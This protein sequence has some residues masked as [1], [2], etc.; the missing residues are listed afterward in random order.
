MRISRCFTL[1]ELLVVIAIIA[2]LAAMLLP[3]L[4]QARERARTISC[5]NNMK[6]IGQYFALY[7]A[8]Y[9]DFFMPLDGWNKMLAKHASIK[10]T[11][12]LGHCPSAPDKNPSGGSLYLTYAYS[13]D[14]WN[15]AWP[16]SGGIAT[17]TALKAMKLSKVVHPSDKAYVAER[18]DNSTGGWVSWT[19]V[20]P[21]TDHK[22][23][24]MH[25]DKSN[26]LFVDGHV[27]MISNLGSAITAANNVR[28]VTWDSGKN[29][30][31][32]K[33]TTKDSWR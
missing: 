33:T 11:D 1:I 24:L 31:I 29:S 30:N 17:G 16:A 4:N 19:G 27:E 32:W 14:W 26:F 22:F 13:G 18:Y 3:A 23:Y 25:S 6:Q 10:E 5:T 7:V 15:T 12:A 28:E 20:A 21:I 2:I 9:E 8:D